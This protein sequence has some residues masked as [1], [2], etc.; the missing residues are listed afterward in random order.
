MSYS[1]I[2]ENRIDQFNP[3]EIIVARKLIMEELS[4]IPETA[5][6][7]VMERM[8]KQNILVRISKGIYC[9]PKTT[10]FG[11]IQVNENAIIQYFT[12]NKKNGM[13][14]GYRLYNNEGLTT[15]IPKN[16]ELYS[17]LITE[18]NKT[19]K[20]ISI[21]KLDMK[22]EESKVKMIENLEIL[23][24]CK[25]I[26]D[27]N[28]HAFVSYLKKAA[29]SYDNEA[30]MEVLGRMKYKKSA[31]A[32]LESILNHYCVKNTL[33]RFLSRTSKY[34]F[35]KIEGIYEIAH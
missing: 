29:D 6:F 2:I 8:V 27:L 4:G 31:I 24:N 28:N 35:P 23:Q 26:E 17:N 14:I 30:A 22:L 11:I 5:F 19:V 25:Q 21:Y 7:K 10:R 33:S 16:T 20:N 34:E 1:S 15:Q 32:F 3:N 12:G 18:D 13:I 9:K